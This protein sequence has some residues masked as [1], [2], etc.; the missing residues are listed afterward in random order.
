[1]LNLFEGVTEM[2]IQENGVIFKAFKSSYR[3]VKLFNIQEINGNCLLIII[4][5]EVCHKDLKNMKVSCIVVVTEMIHFL[6]LFSYLNYIPNN[7][8][9]VLK[10]III[11]AT[12]NAHRTYIFGANYNCFCLLQ[13]N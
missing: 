11:N 3:N 6:L 13:C 8:L 9:I 10:H 2:F 1:M 4:F 5:A 7:T 12:A